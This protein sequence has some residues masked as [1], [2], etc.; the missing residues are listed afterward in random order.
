MI[1]E[2]GSSM[3]SETTC[4]FLYLDDVH[5]NDMHMDDVHPAYRTIGTHV[6][7]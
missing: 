5:L 7:R 1:A 3:R 2:S 4:A 6:F